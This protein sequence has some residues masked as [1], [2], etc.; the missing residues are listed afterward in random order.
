M[1]ILHV[2]GGISADG[3]GTA[4]TTV[5]LT[6]SGIGVGNSVCGAVSY[7]SSGGATITSVKDN[8]GNTYTLGDTVNDAGNNQALT[9]FYLIGATNGPSTI[10]ATISVAVTFRRILADEFSGITVND[11]HTGQFQAAPGTGTNAISS[12]SITPTAS[13]DLIYGATVN[14]NGATGANF[15]AGTGYTLQQ[16]GATTDLLNMASESQVQSVA[17]A[18]SAT[19]TRAV[20]GTVCTTVMAFKVAP[21][22]TS[23]TPGG[24][25]SFGNIVRKTTAIGY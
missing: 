3:T 23:V 7:D 8:K 25:Q 24:W 20:A 1:A 13:G 15:T 12:G 4:T 11:G 2:Q 10:T 21:A 16:S 22:P 6:L 18:I 19:F 17:A 14:T 9:S 5:A